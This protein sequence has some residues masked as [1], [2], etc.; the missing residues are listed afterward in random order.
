MHKIDTHVQCKPGVGSSDQELHVLPLSEVS[1]EVPHT[2][3]RSIRTL[4]DGVGVN[5]ESAVGPN[6]FN[7]VSGLNDVALNIHGKTGCFRD[8]KTEVEGNYSRHAAETNK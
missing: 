7:V 6:I 3:A 2:G 4:D 1:K 8:G 5:V